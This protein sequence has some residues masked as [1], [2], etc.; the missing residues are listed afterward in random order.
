VLLLAILRYLRGSYAIISRNDRKERDL[1]FAR[2]TI[3]INTN[4]HANPMVYNDQYLD[5]TTNVNR[6]S[7]Q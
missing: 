3:E 1:P 4:A 2:I 6:K 7:L 5:N